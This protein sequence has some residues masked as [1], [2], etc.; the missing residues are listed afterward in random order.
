MEQ[1][2]SDTF[3]MYWSNMAKY[4][5]PNGAFEMMCANLCFSLFALSSYFSFFSFKGALGPDDVTWPKYNTTSDLNIFMTVPPTVGAQL[6]KPI[7]DVW[8]QLYSKYYFDD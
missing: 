2:L 7:C 1:K 5:S 6:N 8:T 3:T 4:G